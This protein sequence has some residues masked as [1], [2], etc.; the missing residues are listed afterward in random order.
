MADGG[1]HFTCLKRIKRNFDFV[2]TGPYGWGDYEGKNTCDI[3]A[4]QQLIYV[5]SDV[6]G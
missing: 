2:K 6:A 1:L 4:G 3:N 5:Y